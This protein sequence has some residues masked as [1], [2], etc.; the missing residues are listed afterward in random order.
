MTSTIL[1]G[2]GGILKD[3][4]APRSGEIV[5]ALLS[6]RDPVEQ[7]GAHL[8]RLVEDAA[9]DLHHLQVLLLLVPSALD[10]GH[11]AALILLAGV[12]EIAHSSVLVEHLRERHT[13]PIVRRETLF[14]CFVWSPRL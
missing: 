5:K 4:G 8:H 14:V 10:V 9:A 2:G 1:P 7:R 11:P 3:K 12:D 13:L 6:K